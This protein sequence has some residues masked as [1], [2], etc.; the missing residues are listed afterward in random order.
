MMNTRC[1]PFAIA[2]VT[3]LALFGCGGSEPKPV[4]VAPTVTAAPTATVKPTPKPKPTPTEIPELAEPT[5][6]A[7]AQEKV[8][9]DL[10]LSAT[11]SPPSKTKLEFQW[12]RKMLGI[13]DRDQLADYNEKIYGVYAGG[14]EGKI[15]SIGELEIG[16]PVIVAEIQD[17][18][19]KRPYVVL[20]NISPE[21]LNTF[22]EGQTI[23]FGANIKNI[24]PYGNYKRV[25]LMVCSEIYVEN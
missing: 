11:M 15:V 12:L 6:D 20:Q 5:V 19:V 22:S 24:G 17:G 25:I 16:E 14:W 21:L 8:M 10:V 2:I 23:V 7:T 18:D 13:L 3:S 1:V 4:V 9:P